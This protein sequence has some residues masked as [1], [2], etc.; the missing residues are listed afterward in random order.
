MRLYLDAASLTFKPVALDLWLLEQ[1]HS[2]L[3]PNFQK[4]PTQGQQ[5]K[6]CSTMPRLGTSALQLPSEQRQQ[7]AI[8][9]EGSLKTSP[10][11]RAR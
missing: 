11:K 7:R 1:V 3:Q 9:A 6:P 4:L 8:M 2:L 10:A 5:T